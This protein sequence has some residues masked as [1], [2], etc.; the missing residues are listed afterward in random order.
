MAAKVCEWCGENFEGAKNSRWCKNP[1]YKKCDNPDCDNEFLIKQMKRPARTC[2]KP[3][4]DVMTRLNS[5]KEKICQ[6]KNCGKKFMSSKHDAKFCKEE[7]YDI[8]VVCQ[9]EFTIY[10]VHIPATTCSKQCAAAIT[11]FNERNNKSETTLMKDYGV[12]NASQI[13]AVKEKK[14]QKAQEKYGVDNVS[15]AK[16]IKVKR[17]ATLMKNYGVANPMFS[18]EVKQKLEERTMEKYGVKNV[19]MNEE[20]K[21]KAK[22]AVFAKYGVENIF[23]LPEN[24][25]KAAENSGR[26]ISKVN[27]DWKKI[28]DEE[29]GVSF[30]YE[31]YFGSGYADLGY[32][33][34][35]I[36]INPTITHNTTTSFVHA[37]GRCKVENCVKKSHEPRAADYH[38]KRALA[39]KDNG[40]MLLQYFDWYDP[41]IFINI[42]KAKLKM[43][44]KKVFARKT[45][46][47]EIKQSEANRFLRENHLMGASNGQT[48]CL[49]LFD[50]DNDELIHVQTYGE[51]RLNKNYEWEAIRSCS[52]IGYHV[53]GAFSKCDKYFFNKINPESVISYVDL[54]ISHG[55]TDSMFDGW[56][57]KSLNKPSATWVRIV[58]DEESFIEGRKPLPRFVKDSAARRV[59]AD[60]LLGFEVGDKYPRFDKLGQKITND[61][62]FISEGFVKMYDSG[63]M[64]FVWEKPVTV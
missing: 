37:V 41:E 51:A 3:C 59:S 46:L 14:K 2:S 12:K 30:D 28:L 21:K 13:S 43:S 62:V 36:D 10:N 42:V 4:A 16:E 22:A 1:H 44:D 39:A 24:Q 49:G 55:H 26:R 5:T 64:T 27:Q 50:K 34:L 29:T 6:W 52:K 58:E 8:C 40:Y 54:S 25:K 18:D 20:I 45:V 56:V 23:L 53:P 47:K 11:D 31:I 17:E 33:T 60:R 32:G 57:L 38:Q 61:Y 63:T 15:Q 19:F 9:K 35:L 48:L 7:H